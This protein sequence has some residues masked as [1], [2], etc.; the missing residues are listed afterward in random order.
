MRDLVPLRPLYPQRFYVAIRVFSTSSSSLSP[1]SSSRR[2]NDRAILCGTILRTP[3]SSSR[4]KDE[5]ERNSW[6]R[7]W[8]GGGAFQSENQKS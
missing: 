8:R 6:S 7:E 2:P 3:G 4:R 1:R 5:I